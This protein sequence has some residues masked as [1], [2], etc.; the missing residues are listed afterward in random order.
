MQCYAFKETTREIRPLTRE[1]T[2]FG[3]EL[4]REIVGGGNGNRA[5]EMLTIEQQNAFLSGALQPTDYVREYYEEYLKRLLIDR[6]Y[7][8]RELEREFAKA[9]RKTA[10]VYVEIKPVSE[11]MTR[12]FEDARW[13]INGLIPEGL[14]LIV[15]KPKI[16]KSWFV[17]E[18]AIRAAQGKQFIGYE[19]E[20]SKVLY[21]ALEDSERRLNNRIG[22]LGGI[23]DAENFFYSC[24]LEPLT[25]GG[26]DRIREN[27]DEGFRLII[28]DTYARI[29]AATKRD[30]YAEETQA[31]AGLQGLALAYQS[32]I[33][34]I[35]H[36]RK[37]ADSADLYDQVLGSTALTGTADA[38]IILQR[39]RKTHRIILSQTGRDIE[40]QE[41]AIDFIA[42]EKHVGF[43]Y[44]GKADEVRVSEVE[45]I[46]IDHL[47]STEFHLTPGELSQALNIK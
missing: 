2:P 30:A 10:G 45:R 32:A 14:T 38:T 20:K 15:G 36:A 46:I 13:I 37:N 3:R 39:D 17:L 43:E 23:K 29:K 44:V 33:I 16:G 34:L 1:M 5:M 19:T 41:I 18:S 40:D 22:K 4:I 35:H 25:A 9:T 12:T 21:Y 31:L 6:G 24:T 26:L 28:I 47:K 7:I 27:L 11:L 8:H 42:E